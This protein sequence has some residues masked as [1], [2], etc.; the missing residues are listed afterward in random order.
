M[1]AKHRSKFSNTEI[2]L[3]KKKVVQLYQAKGNN[4]SSPKHIKYYGSLEIKP[5]DFSKNF[6]VA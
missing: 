1:R 3:K 2:D 6:V 4:Q 5:H